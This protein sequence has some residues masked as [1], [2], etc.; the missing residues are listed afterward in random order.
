VAFFADAGLAWTSDL[1][2]RFFGEGSNGSRDWVKSTGVALR[3]NLMGYI[4]GEVD[5]V[6][7]IDRPEKGWYWQFNFI[8]GF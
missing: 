3:F 8:P 7:P 4:I 2:P 5:Y 1:D 6:K